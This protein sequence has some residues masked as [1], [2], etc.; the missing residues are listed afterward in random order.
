[1]VRFFMTIPEAVQLVIQA[2]ALGR[3]GEIFL[4]DMGQPVNILELARDLIRLS[5]FVPYRDIP[6]RITGARP[7]ERLYE[8]MLTK[9]EGV[10]VTK[11]ERIFEAP[12]VPVEAGRVKR[13]AETLLRAAEQADREAMVMG[14]CELLP[15]YTPSPYLAE[16][17][18]AGPVGEER[19]VEGAHPF[20]P[21]PARALGAPG[22]T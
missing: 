4:L 2:G 7:G 14:L 6:I 20:T 5:G 9:E 21:V 15:T 3:A 10:A 22:R 16:R 8:E 11:H 18:E 17:A 1:M 19:E 12:A 13:I